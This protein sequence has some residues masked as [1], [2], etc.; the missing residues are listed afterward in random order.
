ME[1]RGLLYIPPINFQNWSQSASGAW[2]TNVVF[3]GLASL[4][5]F[6]QMRCVPRDCSTSPITAKPQYSHPSPRQDFRAFTYYICNRVFNS[7]WAILT[8]VN[9]RTTTLW[10]LKRDLHWPCRRRYLDHPPSLRV[11]SSLHLRRQA[12]RKKTHNVIMITWIM[13]R[14]HCHRRRCC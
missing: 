1:H 4:I 7:F 5:L 8:A 12:G 2:Y 3:F 10:P 11:S 14:R 9:R 13:S 6:S